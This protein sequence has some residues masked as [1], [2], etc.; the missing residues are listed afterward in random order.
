MRHR[1]F[2]EYGAYPHFKHE[3]GGQEITSVQDWSV[4]AFVFLSPGYER[5]EALLAALSV[6]M[7]SVAV[8][9][10]TLHRVKLA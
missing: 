3:G 2:V 10:M 5:N 7:R 9:A 6:S 4:G 1:C 8:N